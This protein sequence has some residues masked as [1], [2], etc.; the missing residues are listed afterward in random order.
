MNNQ[1][2]Q[3]RILHSLGGGTVLA[4]AH[5]DP[6]DADNVVRV[7]YPVAD[8]V[9]PIEDSSFRDA[10]KKLKRGDTAD[11]KAERLMM[12]LRSIDKE[13]WADQ[14]GVGKIQY[15]PLGKA[16]VVLHRPEM[17]KTI[18]AHLADLRRAQGVQV[19]VE[20]R[21]VLVDAGITKALE[22]YT[23][24]NGRLVHVHDRTSSLSP[25]GEGKSLRSLDDEQLGAILEMAQIDPATRVMQAP[26]VTL[27]NG[28]QAG[29]CN[30]TR[31]AAGVNRGLQYDLRPV[32]EPA[33]KNVR[34]A[35]DMELADDD[36]KA[37]QQLVK[38][39]GTFT[40]PP[41]RTL[42]WR[43]G[44]L[45]ARRQLFMLLTTRVLFGREEERIFLGNLPPLPR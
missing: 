15:F 18:G 28:Q 12:S 10:G 16:L 29:I 40:L 33:G 23:T 32:V 36:A 39:A 1:A 8:L 42:V 7:T 30:M 3:E 45:E 2:R 22:Q 26:R 4:A 20:L 34:L 9:M 41:D 38:A 25:K 11:A 19:A 35:V 37:A 21:L 13:S 24:K 44:E 6:D 14:G 17:Q 5:S 31:N 27:F 43:L